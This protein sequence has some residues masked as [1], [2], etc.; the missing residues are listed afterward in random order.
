MAR[1]GTSSTV[2][3]R[4][5]FLTMRSITCAAYASDLK[6]RNTPKEMTASSGGSARNAAA[7]SGP[8]LRPGGGRLPT[9]VP[10]TARR[11]RSPGRRAPSG[12]R[13]ASP[14]MAESCA[15][16]TAHPSRSSGAAPGSGPEA[17]QRSAEPRVLLGQADGEA[18]KRGLRS[19]NFHVPGWNLGIDRPGSA[20]SLEH[21]Q[22]M[23]RPGTPGGLTHRPIASDR[24]APT[25]C[26]PR[27]WGRP[28]TTSP[29]RGC[30][31]RRT[32]W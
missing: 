13:A 26:A 22:P 31:S 11:S 1:S 15:A 19:P 30:A 2:T 17:M 24:P 21:R 6:Y 10:R 7:A 16:S 20:W 9:R 28:C 27:W 8:E 4:S 14:T 29:G 32:S 3:M 18:R 12:R 25:R 23:R 5:A